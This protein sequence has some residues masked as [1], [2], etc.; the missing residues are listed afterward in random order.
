MAA[1][2]Y[3]PVDASDV[4][5]DLLYVSNGSGR[6]IALAKVCTP[7]IA[8]VSPVLINAHYREWIKHLGGWTIRNL[9]Y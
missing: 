7:M 5:H 8:L 4:I 3:V 1:L 9:F 6:T 2:H